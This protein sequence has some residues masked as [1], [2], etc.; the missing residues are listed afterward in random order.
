MKAEGV[1]REVFNRSIAELE[2]AAEMRA[3]LTLQQP[4]T[5]EIPCR[6][7][8]NMDSISKP[9]EKLKQ[10]L[11][12]RRREQEEGSRSDSRGGGEYDNGG[13][14]VGQ[15][16]RPRPETEGMAKGGPSREKDGDDKEAVQGDPSTSAPSISPSD[17]GKLNGMG[18]MF[19]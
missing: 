17:G 2:G 9:F 4:A 3:C 13:N 16:S 15:S 12:E 5:I 10:R 19:L 18:A 1:C 6:H 14:E 11:K 8:T 7:N